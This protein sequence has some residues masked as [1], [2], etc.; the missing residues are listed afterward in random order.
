MI[1]TKWQNDKMIRVLVSSGIT[2]IKLFDNYK[3]LKKQLSKSPIKLSNTL[4]IFNK[5]IDFNFYLFKKIKVLKRLT[6]KYLS[7]T[8]VDLEFYFV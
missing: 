3:W 5:F 4:F 2:A 7:N 1:T 8:T 6:L